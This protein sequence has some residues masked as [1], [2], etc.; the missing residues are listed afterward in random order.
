[1]EFRDVVHRS[2]NF[3]LIQNQERLY[4]KVQQVRSSTQT[5]WAFER[6]KQIRSGMNNFKQFFFMYFWILL[7]VD[8][9]QHQYPLAPSKKSSQI[10]IASPSTRLNS[11]EDPLY[12]RPDHRASYSICIS[13]EFKSLRPNCRHVSAEAY[14]MFFEE[15]SLRHLEIAR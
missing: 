7:F 1:M 8:K 2:W 3:Q 4:W 10:F 11:P 15:R 9:I 14:L 12:I 6:H 13:S 5:N